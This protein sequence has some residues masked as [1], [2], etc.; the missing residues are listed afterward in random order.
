M[1]LGELS[2]DKDCG[3][4]DYEEQNVL[5]QVDTKCSSNSEFGIEPYCPEILTCANA[6]NTEFIVVKFYL[7]FGVGVFVADVL[8]VATMNGI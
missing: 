3:C 6:E 8:H 7:V 2:W 5:T 1:M 4:C